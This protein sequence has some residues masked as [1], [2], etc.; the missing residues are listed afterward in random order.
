[1]WQINSYFELNQRQAHNLHYGK[2]KKKNSLYSDLCLK[3]QLSP[4]TFF[5]R[6]LHN[7]LLQLNP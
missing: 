4:E 7:D 6:T 2:K 3:I 5:E 1:M